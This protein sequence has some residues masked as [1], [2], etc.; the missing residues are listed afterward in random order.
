MAAIASFDSFQR[1]LVEEGAEIAGAWKLP[2]HYR[3]T[4]GDVQEVQRRARECHAEIIV[5]TEKDAV[6]LEEMPVMSLDP[7]ILVLRIEAHFS[8]GFWRWLEARL[9]AA[10]NQLAP[11]EGAY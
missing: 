6:K 9:R 8:S 1:T 11:T 2:D 4:P 5:V 3:Y 7:P 10:S